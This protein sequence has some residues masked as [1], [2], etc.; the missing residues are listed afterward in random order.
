MTEKEVEEFVDYMLTHTVEW[1]DGPEVYKT[2]I[3][4]NPNSYAATYKDTWIEAVKLEFC[5]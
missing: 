3:V 5:K 1:Y 2:R 4:P